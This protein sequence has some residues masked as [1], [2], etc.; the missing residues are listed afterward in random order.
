MRPAQGYVIPID[1]LKPQE[2]R[3]VRHLIRL[4]QKGTFR[5][6]AARLWRMYQPEAQAMEA[7]PAVQTWQLP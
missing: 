7:G 2:A 6:P 3:V 4:G 1:A 5:L